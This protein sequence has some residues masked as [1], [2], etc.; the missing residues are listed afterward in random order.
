MMNECKEKINT[1]GPEKRLVNS[2]ELCMCG[3][4]TAL[5]CVLSPMVIPIGPVPVSPAV[6]VICLTAYLLG[7]RLAA[8]SAGIY[9]LTGMAGM[10]VF[11]GYTG[12]VG[13]LAGPTGGYLIGYLFTAFIGGMACEKFNRKTLPSAFGMGAGVAAA[14]LFGT[15]WFVHSM[16]AGLVY[17]LSVCVFPFIPLDL[18]KIAAA[19]LLGRTVRAALGRS[20]FLHKDNEI[21]SV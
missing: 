10:P 3:L 13:K 15:I 6:F 7:G 5:M 18:A 12:G 1:K 2:R 17:A 8:M 11:S 14:Y 16:N 4:M 9:L 19:I 20:G 21:L